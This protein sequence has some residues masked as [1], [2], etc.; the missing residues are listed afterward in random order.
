MTTQGQALR[1]PLHAVHVEAGARIVEFAGWDMPIQYTGVLEEHRAVRTRAGLFDVSHM[2]EL[3]VRGPQAQ[4]LLQALTCNDLARLSPG[5]AHYNGLMTPHGAFVD[6]LVIYRLDADDFM[7]VV[8]AANA[9]KDFAWMTSQGRSFDAEI[10]DRSG[11]WSL[12]SLQGP[13]AQEILT[14]MT[15]VDLGEIRYYGFR[16]GDVAGVP[17]L[18]SR[19]GYTGEDGFELYAPWDGAERLWRSTMAAGA[20]H[21][22]VP[23]GLAARDTLRLE[24]CMAL[25]GNDIDETTTAYEADLAWIVKLDKGTF[26]GRDALSRERA[27]G[28]RRRLAA[29]TTDGRAIARQGHAVHRAGG[30]VVGAVTSGSFS[31]TLQ[32]NVGLAYVPPDLAQPGAR[33]EIEIRGRREAATVAPKPFYKRART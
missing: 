4:A 9:A 11:D 8:N 30:D 17:C 7:V 10:A 14:A 2:G 32:K 18:I 12:L 22:L 25:Y 33:L 3:S 23:A 1:T 16:R 13:L 29:F 15:A 24:A 20:P 19:T 27:E 5:R 31:P 26:T 21:G 28:S 6:D